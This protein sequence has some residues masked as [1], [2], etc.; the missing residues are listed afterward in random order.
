MEQTS[1][2]TL[3]DRRWWLLLL[4]L[5]AAWLGVAF[6]GV[7]LGAVSVEAHEIWAIVS[8]LGRPPDPALE[9][10]AA[11]V[12]EVRLPRVLMGGLA[13]LGLSVAGVAWQGVLRN[14]LADPYL[15]GASAGGALGA[16]IAIL[17]GLS[18]GFA[19]A[20]PALAFAGAIGAVAVV[21]QLAY[22]PGRGL[23]VDRLILAGVAVSA[24]F[25]ACLSLLA[26]VRSESFTQ[27]YFWLMGGLSGRGWEQVGLLAPYWAVAMAGILVFTPRLN[28]LQLGEATAHA[29]G[30]DVHRDQRWVIALAALLTGAIVSVCGM[31]A[32]VG[33]IVP[34]LAR[35]MV[36]QDLRRVLPAAGLMGACLLTAADLLARLVWVPI[37][38]PV[39]VLTA[40][41]GAPFFLFLLRRQRA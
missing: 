40:L 41:A 22:Q 19:F 9:G 26:F 37:E 25:S 12:W 17:F 16:G 21:Y 24:F 5:L 34:H 15:I 33:L 3:L 38:V 1:A 4:A 35:L 18:A 10:T 7:R 23:S 13:G 36:G 32:F 30:V 6:L 31:I 11:I 2:P 27:L 14:P 28:L 8:H 20:V 39:G 29:L